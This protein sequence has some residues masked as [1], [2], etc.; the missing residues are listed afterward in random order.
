MEMEKAG[1]CVAPAAAAAAATALDRLLLGLY[2]QSGWG[3]L[4]AQLLHGWPWLHLCFLLLHS[5]HD[6]VVLSAREGRGGTLFCVGSDITGMLCW[7]RSLLTA[8]R[9]SISALARDDGWL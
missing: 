5:P 3:Y 2:S 7:M 6:V 8:T 4:L 1:G 9:P